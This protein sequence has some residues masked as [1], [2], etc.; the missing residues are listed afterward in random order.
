MPRA[1]LAV[2]LDDRTSLRFGYARY[3]IPSEDNFADPPFAGF[4]AVNFLE[5]PY[6]GF[7]ATQNI[8]APLAGVP[9]AR[10]SDPFP[11][12]SN[13]LIQPR[14]KGFGRY[15]GLGGSNLLWFHQDFKRGVNDRINVSLSRMLPNEIVADVTYFANFG[16]D[17][18][19]TRNLNQTD[20]RL[21]YEFKAALDA[22]VPNPFYQ[23]LTPQTFPGPLRNQ[24]TVR[25]SS[26]LRPYPQYGGLFELYNPGRDLR[27]H[28]LQIR[29]QRA[30]RHGYNFLF[31]Y[32][33]QRERSTEYFDEVAAYLNELT[34][35]ESSAP[36]HRMSVAGIYELPFGQARAHLSQLPGLLDGIVGGWQI[37]GVFYFNSGQYL[38]FGSMLVDGDP[39]IDNPTPDRWF[40]TSKFQR[41]PAFTPR[42]NPWQ[43]P[44]LTGPVF[45]TIDSTLTKLVRVTGNVR[46]EFKL[47]AYNVTNRL[48]RA[49]PDL[50]VLSSNFGRTLRQG[51]STGRQ[52]ELGLKILF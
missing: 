18:P 5:P 25:L 15:L 36:R 52:V 23:Y 47:A 37:A 11:A 45:W 40:D 21:S 1:G 34:F 27:Y 32:N 14:G 46:T 10:F 28:A 41:Q 42:T 44:G 26:L 50:S 4:E 6:F 33:Y 7:D 39:T 35:Q 16:H 13:P 20:P 17:L 29:V 12:A 48:N 3:T 31:G 22:T 43:Y 2:Q 9:Q 51:G 19:Y 49:N 38:R 24:S 30:F 8:T